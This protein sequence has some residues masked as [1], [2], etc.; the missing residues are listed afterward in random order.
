M[1]W[2]A[3]DSE[4]RT[5]SRITENISNRS[6]RNQFQAT[7]EGNNV[8]GAEKSLKERG[9]RVHGGRREHR[10]PGATAHS[11]HR[12]TFVHRRGRINCGSPNVT[13]SP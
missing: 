1:P 10:R 4:Q 6:T 2:L 3:F 13:D 5:G 8:G 12:D 9:R 7:P 11:A